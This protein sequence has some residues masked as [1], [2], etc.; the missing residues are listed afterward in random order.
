MKTSGG[1]VFGLALLCA[2]A[3]CGTHMT[4]VRPLPPDKEAEINGLVESREAKLTFEDKRELDGKDVRVTAGSIRFLERN[5]A[6]S[7]R[8]PSWLPE[9]EKPLASVRQIEV[10]DSAR[11]G[12]QGLGIGAAIGIVLGAIGGAA[13]AS[14]GQGPNAPSGSTYAL[15][16]ALLGGLGA[17]ILGAAIGSATGAARTIELMDAPSH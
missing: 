12:F 10:R 14:A 6:T 8:E 3:G 2:G 17:G 4:V 5:P 15:A 11:G 7:T 1:R 16:G 13:V 9:T